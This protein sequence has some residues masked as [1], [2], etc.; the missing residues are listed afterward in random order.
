MTRS[1]VDGDHSTALLAAVELLRAALPPEMSPTELIAAAA[2]AASPTRHPQSSVNREQALKGLAALA[3]ALQGA[4]AARAALHPVQFEVIYRQLVHALTIVHGWGPSSTSEEALGAALVAMDTLLC[5]T[6]LTLSA[7]PS[8]ILCAPQMRPSTGHLLSTLLGLATTPMRLSAA[9]RGTCIRSV[10][11]VCELPG[12][13][14]GVL[15]FFVP[16]VATRLALLASGDEKVSTTLLVELLGATRS[17]LLGCFSDRANVAALAQSSRLAESPM[18][19]V[20]GL[21]AKIKRARKAAAKAAKGSEAAATKAATTASAVASEGRGGGGVR[22]GGGDGEIHDNDDSMM[23]VEITGRWLSDAA[24]RLL[25]LLKRLC[26]AAAAGTWRARA[27]LVKLARS[28]LLRCTLSLDACVPLLLE[29]TYASTRDPYSQVARLAAG[30]LRRVGERLPTSAAF[31]ALVR[32]GFDA[33]LRILP[34]AIQR[35]VHERAKARAFAVLSAQLDLVHAGG[36][37]PRLLSAKLGALSA[38]L[39]TSLAMAPEHARSIETRHAIASRITQRALESSLRAKEEEKVEA[40]L[41]NG[42]GGDGMTEAARFLR[43]ARYSP[44]P[45]VHL[46]DSATVEAAAELCGKMGELGCLS[47]VAHQFLLAVSPETVGGATPRRAE[48]LWVLDYAIMGA[49]R[50]RRWASSGDA[51][52]RTYGA[53]G[54]DDALGEAGEAADER[55]GGGD[56]EGS[57]RAVGGKPAPLGGGFDDSDGL[58]DDDEDGDDSSGQG[59]RSGNS[60]QTTLVAMDGAEAVECAQMILRALLDPLVWN[61]HEMGSGGADGMSQSA[62]EQQLV[63]LEHELLLQAVG[64]AFELIAAY[65]G[66]EEGGAAG[67]NGR[68]GRE[69]GDAARMLVSMQ[70]EVQVTLCRVLFPLLERLG[71]TALAVSAAAELTLCRV[72]VAL[73]D[74]STGSIAQ[75][76]AANT[77]YLLDALSARLRRVAHY[78]RTSQVLQAILEFGGASVLPIAK[79]VIA[80]V[81]AIIDDAA[82]H[83]G[84]VSVAQAADAQRERYRR[85][86]AAQLTDLQISRHS[87]EAREAHEA[88]RL[89]PAAVRPRAGGGLVAG[90]AYLV[91]WLRALRVL[92]QVCRSNLE[93]DETRPQPT[94]PP[95]PTIYPGE[96]GETLDA[97]FGKLLVRVVPPARYQEVERVLGLRGAH[98]GQGGGGPSPGAGRGGDDED[99]LPDPLDVFERRHELSADEKFDYFDKYQRK[100]A[101][102]DAEA[103]RARKEEE[104][105]EE[106]ANTPPKAGQLALEALAKAEVLLLSGHLATAHTLCDILIEIVPAL[107]PWPRAL[108]PAIYPLWKPLLCL[109]S[110]DDRSL[111]A[112][113]IRVLSTAASSGPIGGEIST[114]VL[115]DAIGHLLRAIRRNVQAPR[116]ADLDGLAVVRGAGAPPG[117]GATGNGGGGGAADVRG[118]SQ[119]V[120]LAAC[121]CLRTLCEAPRATK[122]EVLPILRA[123]APLFSRHQPERVQRA[124]VDLA[125]DLAALEPDVVWLFFVGWLPPNERWPAPPPKGCAAPGVRGLLRTATPLH[126]YAVNAR[127]VVTRIG[128]PITTTAA[129][130]Q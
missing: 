28:L 17:L 86:E 20:S 69:G 11:V 80:D 44:K 41:A 92:V 8:D 79:D 21:H 65:A 10:R 62:A 4:S 127:E 27:S 53:E 67:G 23:K 103:E 42:G 75:L 71:E 98:D 22:G 128:Q 31:S 26:A 6:A 115:T 57:E 91:G 81:L 126:D 14:E 110:S 88:R 106:A 112:H 99:G 48:A 25:P 5:Q 16:G 73:R 45:F 108:L 83:V 70:A 105:R 66:S 89:H 15:G 7:L 68:A 122:H 49:T 34:G 109:F 77:D 118:R 78:P 46:R 3:K 119:E 84:A 120:L 59:D 33:Q 13:D 125:V 29:H 101:Q 61:A 95:Q 56:S 60:G 40:P 117:G 100:Q 87:E 97:F 9:K 93:A 76:L 24:T 30:A 124:A 38:A 130:P 19:W 64:S 51:A 18:A 121:E 39:L 36:S 114:R 37:L 129:P 113:A 85:L 32:D 1:V 52:T 63:I 90:E 107:S 96:D 43:H 104:E 58:G 74:P 123:A 116:R 12:M 47:A 55:A 2:A 50:A 82:P 54:A 102:R 72:C 35:G 111:A 94:K